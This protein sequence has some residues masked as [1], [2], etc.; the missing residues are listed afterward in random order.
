MKNLEIKTPTTNQTMRP[1]SIYA[2]SVKRNGNPNEPPQ[3]DNAPQPTNKPNDMRELMDM[4]KQ[5]MQ[6]M[7]TLT[8]ILLIL[9]TKVSHSI[10]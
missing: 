5:L 10:P 1:E 3:D 9:T 7:S 8:N 6:Q 4:F 2:Q